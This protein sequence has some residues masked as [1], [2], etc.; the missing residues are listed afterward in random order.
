MKQG[1]RP[2]P[3]CGVRTAS[4]TLHVQKAHGISPSE[5]R[6]LRTPPAPRSPYSPRKF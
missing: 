6:E 5:L 2:C 4:V 1:W 3:F